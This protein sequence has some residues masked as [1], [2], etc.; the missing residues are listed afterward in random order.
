MPYTAPKIV[1]TPP[2]PRARE[3]IAKD[4]RLLS[5]SL[6]RSS[7]LVGV[8]AERV[9]VEDVDGN[10]FLDFGSGIAVNSL[11]HRHREVIAAIKAQL[12]R[13]IF[14]NSLDYYTLPQIEYAEMLFKVTPG[15]FAKRV[16]YCNS[17]SEA[18][19]TA[20]KMAKWHTRRPYGIGFVNGFHGRTM[21]AVSF[22][23]TGVSARRGFAPM[24]PI[25]HF[26]PYPYC[27]RCLFN[28]EYPGCDLYCLSY[29]TDVTLKKIT[30]PD[31]VAF[32]IV[33][34][35]QGA[36]GYIVPPQDFLPRRDRQAARHHSDRGRGAKRLRPH[37]KDVGLPALRPGT[38]HHGHLQ[39][40]RPWAACRRGGGPGRA[41]GLGRGGPRGHPQR[42]AGGHGGG[43][44]CIKGDRE[45]GLGGQG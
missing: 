39:G 28:R 15:I 35:V 8:K 40:F 45:G 32:I 1:V 44:G 34:S 11:G 18:I 9:F 6:S 10:V 26:V 3:W 4:H 30:P 12:D 17:G 38:G 33:E 24:Y 5:P 20:I 42:R 41:D 22:T 2:G 29:L 31:E 13:L 23:T 21:G 36:G 16:F 27:Y 19:D 14:L 37:G 25:G 43:Q 7:A